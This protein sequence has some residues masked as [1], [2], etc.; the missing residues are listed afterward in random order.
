MPTV[1][2]LIKNLDFPSELTLNTIS[3]SNTEKEIQSGGG[4]NRKKESIVKT[5]N[6]LP[7]NFMENN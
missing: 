5:I 7:P 4:S 6:I 3:K 2:E 1:K